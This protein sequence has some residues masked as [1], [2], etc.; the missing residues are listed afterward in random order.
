MCHY[1]KD[2]LKQPDGDLWKMLWRAIVAKNPHAIAVTKVKGH[3][4]EAMIQ[5]G[6]VR[7]ADKEGNDSSD[8]AATMGTNTVRQG[9]V[10]AAKHLIKRQKK[11]G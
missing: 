8:L 10:A 3:A 7:V 4:T 1:K 5:D 11:Y 6:S 9:L 2:W